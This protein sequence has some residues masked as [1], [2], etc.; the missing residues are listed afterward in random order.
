MSDQ[1]EFKRLNFFT[2]FFTQA[3]DWK[4]GQAFHVEKQ[5]LLHR[6]LHKPG[7]MQGLQ[8]KPHPD[9]GLK[10]Q[11]TPGVA[12][13]G[14]GN[15]IVLPDTRPLAV[16][17]P[18]PLPALVYVAIEFTE[19]ES[20]YVSNAMD[21]D[22]SGYSR[23]TEQAVVT[24]MTSQ[25]DNQLKVELARIALEPGVTG[26]VEPAEPDNPLANEIDRRHVRRA[27][28]VDH[29]RDKKLDALEARLEHLH[30]YHLEKQRRHNRGLFH[31]GLM[32][33]M[34]DE[35]DVVPAGGLT[36]HVK[37]GVALDGAGNEIYLDSSVLVTLESPAATTRVYL[38]ARY[39]DRFA[40]YVA[41]LDEPFAGTYRTAQVGTLTTMPDNHTW[42]ELARLDLEAGATEVRLPVDRG[43]PQPNEIDRR[44]VEWAAALAVVAP[45]LP[46]ALR[47]RIAQLMRDKRRDFAALAARF[48]VL[49]ATD[50]RQAALNLETLA[51]NDSLKHENLR[52]VLTMLEVLEQDVGQ[53]IG[54]KYLPVVGKTEYQDYVAAV[55]A[56][57]NALYAGESIDMILTCQATVTMAAR[58]LAEVVFQGPIADAGPDQTVTSTDDEAAVTL[59]AS[60]S[61]ASGDSQIINYRWEKEQ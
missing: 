17:L 16:T 23:V 45:K 52:E 59:D 24:I 34:L 20:D 40:D 7:I 5:K 9:G 46:T 42:L 55:T 41:N 56:L 4:E 12:L 36:V 44:S 51:R 14:A 60:Q 61:Q 8:V 37:S 32:R 48:P 2:G 1:T 25:P 21:P 49:S 30:A 28:S 11:V 15:L 6:G 47:E 57:R 29:D 13:D 53:E 54:D 26:L 10:L 43:H 50:L 35:F 33:S 19:T 22:Y 31:A 38:A 3:K 58:E 18:D 27:G 39:Q